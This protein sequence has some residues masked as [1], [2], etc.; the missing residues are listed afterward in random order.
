MRWTTTALRW[1]TGALLVTTLLAGAAGGQPG[2]A[3]GAKQAQAGKPEEELGTLIARRIQRATG[4][5]VRIRKLVYELFTSTFVGEGISVGPAGRPYV[6]IP[7]LKLE[8]SL[9]AKGA[10]ATVA[11]VEVRKPRLRARAA[12]LKR[13]YRFPV[14]RQTTVRV[15]QIV[16]GRATIELDGGQIVLDGLALTVKGL[17][18]PVTRAGTPPALTGDVSLRAAHVR[19]GALALKDLALDGTLTGKALEV[20]RLSLGLPGGT[21]TLAGNVGFG[22]K[23]GPGPVDLSGSFEAVIDGG[24]KLTGTVRISGKTLDRLVLGGKVEGGKLPASGGLEGAPALDLRM[25]A[26]RRALR[27]TLRAWRLR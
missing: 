27:G 19:L 3:P 17:A 18:V 22:G 11:L 23:K 21:A 14:Q 13:L 7:D 6:V 12:W 24:A 20:K 9:M 5:K 1:T 16:G 10:G 2:P 15:G 26:G 25:R 4:V 8:L